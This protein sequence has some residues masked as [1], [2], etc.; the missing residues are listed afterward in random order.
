MFQRGESG[1]PG[2]R[3][4][5]TQE[6]KNFEKQCRAWAN[7]HAFEKLKKAA[8]SFDQKLSFAATQELLDRAFGKAAI[9]QHL[10]ADVTQH[11]QE[12]ASSLT[13]ALARLVGGAAQ[14]SGPAAGENRVGGNA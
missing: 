2:G 13:D 9:I 7:D 6:Q 10:E 11:T 4:K 1:N 8:D 14:G 12:T 5:K 3:P